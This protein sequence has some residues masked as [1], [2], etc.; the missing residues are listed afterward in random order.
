MGG[1]HP[2]TCNRDCNKSNDASLTASASGE[3]V[4]KLLVYG[5]LSYQCMCPE[6]TSVD[7]LKELV[8]EVSGYYCMCP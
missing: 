6:A 5:V 1:S 7:G 2:Q 8:Y 3:W 4:L